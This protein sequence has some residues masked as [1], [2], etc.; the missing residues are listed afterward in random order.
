M[1]V[2]VVLSEVK[3]DDNDWYIYEIEGI[4]ESKEAAIDLVRQKN[5]ELYNNKEDDNWNYF[6]KI[7]TVGK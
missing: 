6:I 1:K 5:H 7:C 2:Y 4:F 3:T